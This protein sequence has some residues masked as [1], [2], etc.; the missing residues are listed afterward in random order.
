MAWRR[1]GDK[2]LSEPM[3]EYYYWTLRNKLQWNL[4]RNSNIFIW[5]NAFERVVCET[6]SILSRPQCVNTMSPSEVIM[7]E[8]TRPS[9]VQI[10]A[11]RLLGTKPLS[12]PLLDC[13]Y[14]DH[15]EQTWVKFELKYENFHTWKWIWKC[16]L[17]NDSHFVLALMCKQKLRP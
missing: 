11:C 15:W 1:S 13:C 9:F 4:N 2:P 7:C 3:L 14:L 5:E 12:E 8:Q 17:Q 10:R 6:A 16:H